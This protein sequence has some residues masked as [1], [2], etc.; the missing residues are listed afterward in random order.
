MSVHDIYDKLI[1]DIKGDRGSDPFS[2]MDHSIDNNYR[3]LKVLEA[4]R[5]YL[6]VFN[7]SAFVTE[8]CV[9]DGYEVRI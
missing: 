3:L 9:D 1:N 5:G 7:L 4:G 2:G 6:H 8:T